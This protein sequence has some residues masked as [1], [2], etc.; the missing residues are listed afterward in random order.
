[1]A[2]MIG[3]IDSVEGKF[4]LK[5]K[6]GSL[7]EL[8]VGDTIHEGDVIVGD[9][10]NSSI[11]NIIVAT[12]DG[13]DILVMGD[14]SQLFDLSLLQEEF[15]DSDSI[16]QKESVSEMIAQIEGAD[17]AQELDT[18]AGEEGSAVESTEG[19][20][21]EFA[22][23]SNASVDIVAQLRDVSAE[24]AY[25]NYINNLDDTE[26]D[27]R[28][29][30]LADTPEKPI[31][32]KVNADLSDAT[33]TGSLDDNIT[34]DNTPDIV[35]HTVAGSEV[36]VVD[37]N[38]NTLGEGVADANGDF[39]ITLTEL[40][41]GR[42]PLL[43]AA[44]DPDGNSGV[45]ELTIDI[46]TGISNPNDPNT[47][48]TAE[49]VS[50]PNDNTPE[51]SGT[52]EP[53][54]EVTIEYIDANGD[55]Q[56]VTVP[57]DADGNYTA[58]LP[59][60]LPEGDNPLTVT[61]TD[62]AGNTSSTTVN[63]P[64][65]TV[66]PT[67]TVVAPN[68]TN[69]DTP[70]ISGTTDLPEDTTVTIT[71]TDA[72]GATQTFTATVDANGNYTADVPNA[73]PE[74]NYDVSVSVT[75]AAGN[76]TTASD[77]GNTVDTTA[78]TAPVVTISEDSN[79]D[80]YINADELNGEVDVSIDVSDANVGDT[81]SIVNPN[82][83]T[84]DVAITQDMIEN[85]YATSYPAPDE[86]ESITISAT[87]SDAAGNTSGSS[88][89]SAVVDTN[90]P[91]S[92]I[93][94]IDTN[95]NLVS[96]NASNG[97]EVGITALASDPDIGDSVTYSLSDD[98]NGRFTIDPVT[99]IVTVAD[100]S[101]LDFES[102][103]SHDITVVATSTD[104]STSQAV[105]TINIGDNDTGAGGG[106]SG[107]DT[108]NAVSAITDIDIN[109]NLVSEN[110]SNGTEVGITALASDPDIG[111]TVTYSLSDD[112]NGRFTIDPVTGIVTVAD[113][114]QLDFES[115]TSHD[116][117]VVAT[118]SDGS[119]SQ[120]V[121][122]VNIGDV[123]E[124]PVVTSETINVDEDAIITG[125]IQAS[126]PENDSLT[127]S[128]AAGSTAPE[129]LTLHPDG[130]Y[131]FDADAYDDIDAGST[132]T[133]EVPITVDDGNG[134]QTQTTLTINIEGQNNDLTYVSES[135]GYA[136]VVGYY[137]TDADGNPV[138]GTVVIDD[139]N[140]MVSGTHLADLEPG[141]YDF[142]I[143]ADGASLV[144]ENS[145]ITFD[146][147]GDKPVLLIDGV[148][149]SKPVYYTE[150]TFNPD[151]ADHFIFEPD[152]EGGTTIKIE[153][154]PNL[155]DADFGDV[156]MHTNFEMTDK[157]VVDTTPSA[158]NEIQLIDLNTDPN[159]PP[160]STTTNVVI[161]LDVSGSMDDMVTAP[162]GSRVTRLELAKDGL[163]DMINNYDAIGDVNVKIVAFS[164]DATASDW[165]SV[166]DAI[167]YLDSLDAGGGT[168]YEDAVYETYN[169]YVEPSADN[170]VVYFIS[171]GEPTIE[172]YGD[173]GE[174]LFGRRGRPL[175][176]SEEGYLDQDYL[177][178]W[179]DFVN[180]YVDDLHVVALGEGISNTM[181]L[182]ELATAGSSETEIVNDLY[183]VAAA[184]ITDEVS[185][186][187]LDNVSGGNGEISIDSIVVGADTYTADNFPADGI[188][189][190]GGATLTFDF[191]TGEY[192]YTASGDTF[193]SDTTES[194]SVNVSDID[195][196]TTSFDVSVVVDANDGVPANIEGSTEFDTLILDDA[197]IDFSSL[198]ATISNIEAVEL[199]AGNQAIS[200]LTLEDVLDMT[201]D[202][203]TLRIEGDSTDTISLDTTADGSGEWTLGS[204]IVTDN[205][206]GETYQEYT[207][208]DN[209]GNNVT[210]EVNT[211]IIVD[212]S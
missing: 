116:I 183:S 20:E 2:A 175:T 80:G 63:A 176:D 102:A 70:P 61:V 60:A 27:R 129:G 37:N 52:T 112:A 90:V 171:D 48:I 124:A 42:E 24:P 74:G 85:G 92:A 86:G 69:D 81:L 151:D 143:I 125:Q 59:D 76:T 134:A 197:A 208:I 95:E 105:M 115:D 133:I 16:T 114:S 210:L 141:D 166:S 198:S 157:I 155:G 211:Q 54:A 101:Q 195:G 162:D 39:L 29:L 161:T 28:R 186:N 103:P 108:D 91:V 107:G 97:T 79:D 73:L 87:I 158:T 58:E 145:V 89:D 83:T 212:E 136:N 207:G 152:G 192:L 99:G 182:D 128:I 82:G 154:L 149:S 181:Y 36:V 160:P 19:G 13:N 62:P 57:S 121:M 135:A 146:N 3:T 173:T 34:A 120:A 77:T 65:D 22:Q 118:S 64:V 156:V 106:N 164:T 194:F 189:T 169:D 4:Y 12:I 117:T 159:T 5:G 140:G 40:P 193:T 1:M 10:N 18:A 47:A 33:N 66:A 49:V 84:T 96:E 165:M 170:T 150:P 100:D 31:Y 53:N 131:T 6:D 130:T 190:D 191:E 32:I 202:N 144:D 30:L 127:F 187:V 203:N 15:S 188:V 137:T 177:D 113:D 8:S 111:D 51:V 200:S 71:V 163:V 44:T 122:T 41:D 178:G 78:P 184:V 50:P 119:T 11:D 26:A 45:T 9:K 172:N 147:S 38:G 201:D 205:D 110:A 109:E 43:V 138:V 17:N 174:V 209:N 126:D 23:M 21:A 25:D 88:T 94:D 35:G 72:T 67:L 199:S 148:P 123:N 204:G 185:G 75:D 55:P 168:N 98:A 142:F 196:D 68:I 46:D 56:S 14:K 139:Q 167:A 104:G 132:Q 206:T 180:T 93:T 7:R 179:S 153:D